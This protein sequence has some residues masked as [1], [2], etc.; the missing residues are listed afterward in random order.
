[1]K[2][3]D[4]ILNGSQEVCVYCNG[5]RLHGSEIKKLAECD[6]LTVSVSDSLVCIEVNGVY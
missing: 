3:K 4:F 1:M 6:I 2:Y 5:K